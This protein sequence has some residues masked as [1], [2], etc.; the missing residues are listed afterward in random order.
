MLIIFMCFYMGNI[1]ARHKSSDS[2]NK[3][4][5]PHNVTEG[6][7]KKM[8]IEGHSSYG[9]SDDTDHYNNCDCDNTYIPIEMECMEEN[10]LRKSYDNFSSM[11][12]KKRKIC[13]NKYGTFNNPD[14]DSGIDLE[15]ELDKMDA[16]IKWARYRHRRLT[17]V[18]WQKTNNNFIFEPKI[19]KEYKRTGYSKY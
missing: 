11:V 1:F 9:Y 10:N 17:D 15:S 18:A 4:N 7:K 8:M 19:I 13:K 5:N 2:H 3:Y 12:M 14:F 16:R 6:C